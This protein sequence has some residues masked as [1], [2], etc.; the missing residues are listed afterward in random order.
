M[1]KNQSGP[2]AVWKAQ[3]GEPSAWLSHRPGFNSQLSCATTT[4]PSS[5]MIARVPVWKADGAQNR[6]VENEGDVT[7]SLLEKLIASVN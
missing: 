2:R 6:M 5:N 3:L 1:E 7:P 4:A